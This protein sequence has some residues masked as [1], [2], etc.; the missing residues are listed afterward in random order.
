MDPASCG[1]V[2]ANLQWIGRPSRSS[3]RKGMTKLLK[4]ERERDS[5]IEVKERERERE[6]DIDRYIKYIIHNMR[7]LGTPAC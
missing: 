6:I 3:W 5:E 7:R 1:F 4:L 2:I